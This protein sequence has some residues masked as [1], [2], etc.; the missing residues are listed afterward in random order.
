MNSRLIRQA[1]RAPSPGVSTLY[2]ILV[3]TSVFMTPRG[4]HGQVDG[5]SI[6]LATSERPRPSLTATEVIQPVRLDGVLD[7]AVWLRAAPA[8]GFVQAEPREGLPASE[9]TEVWVAYDEENLYVAAYLHDSQPDALVVNDIRKDFDQT[10]QDVFSVILDT[11][12]DRRNGYVFMTNPAGARGDLQMANEGREVNQNWDAIWAVETR[13]VADGWTVEME[14]PFRALRFDLETV[15]R[16]GVNFSRRLRRNN[17]IAYWAPLPRAYDLMRLSLA[18]NLLGL[19]SAAKGR[20]LR[21]KPYVLAGAVR[22][23]GTEKFDGKQEFGID[24]KYGLTRS[25]TLDITTNPDFAQVE[26]DQ[27]QVNLTQFSLFFPEKREFFLENS[28]IFFVGAGAQGRNRRFRQFQAQRQDLLVF[29]S[30]RIGLDGNRQAV[31]IKAGVRLTGKIAGLQVGGLAMRTD[32]V[33]GVPGAGFGV[34]RLRKNIRTSSDVGA[35]FLTRNGRGGS[36]DRN[37]VFGID[38]NFRLPAEIAWTSY[39]VGS[40]TPGVANGQ[41]A[42]R[43]S[44][45][46][47]GNFHQFTVGVLQIGEGFANDLGFLRRTGVRKWTLASGLRPRPEALRKK[48]IREMYLHFFWNYFQDLDGRKRAYSFHNGYSIFLNNGGLADL[49]VTPTFERITEEFR[50]DDRIAPIPAGSYG[51]TEWRLRVSTDDSRMVSLLGS[52]TWGGLWSGTQKTLN[53]TVTIKP[54]YKFRASLG[55]QRTAAKLDTPDAAFTT[56]FWTMRANYSFNRNMFF[57]ALVQYDAAQDLFNSNVRFKLIHHALSD[58]FVV[59][60]EQRF[61]TG[62]NI[63]PGRS[64]QVKVTQMVAF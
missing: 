15:G 54:M 16:W 41:Y 49:S 26:Q 2:A 57:D 40:D 63:R 33:G 20:D 5:A 25:L 6:G 59:W 29:F 46:R 7:D 60:N 19:P 53:G 58:L 13:R 31:P 21:V 43:T 38:G 47:E 39:L 27:Q 34:V 61:F 56:S 11:F 3:F 1:P 23:T 37:L 55:L 50:I 36:G 48:G 8:T 62:E 18:G 4:L 51:W 44:L 17:E 10:S 28:G 32:D 24:V 64:F 14:I 42:F 45:N 12:A 22:G 9:P 35:I 30:R 52:Y